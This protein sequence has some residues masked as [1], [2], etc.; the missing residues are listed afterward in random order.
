MKSNKLSK[1]FLAVISSAILLQTTAFAFTPEELEARDHL[2]RSVLASDEYQQA[3]NHRLETMQPLNEQQTAFCAKLAEVGSR[4]DQQ[5]LL[6]E[7]TLQDS[8][9]RKESEIARLTQESNERLALDCAPLNQE[10]DAA[11][12]AFQ[13]ESAPFRAKI[14][15]VLRVR[16]ER[17]SFYSKN[18]GRQ[19]LFLDYVDDMDSAR[20]TV[21]EDKKMEPF[22][23]AIANLRQR[24]LDPIESKIESAK[25]ASKIA[26][27]TQIDPLVA[28]HRE[29]KAKLK[30]EIQTLQ[31]ECEQQL[32]ALRASN[33]AFNDA[34]NRRSSEEYAKVNEAYHQAKRRLLPQYPA[35]RGFLD[36]VDRTAAQQA[37]AAGA[38]AQ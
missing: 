15:A 21:E 12:A 9:A 31:A 30:P 2:H 29:L 13:E 6:L 22:K 23:E 20:R 27:Y 10:R 19:S 26:L 11:E 38:A 32:N 1:L 25:K 8:K 34:I 24:Y 28:R 16:Q 14:S 36:S 7:Q 37:P 18:A 33:A 4:Y 3:Q 17:S 35:L 5:V